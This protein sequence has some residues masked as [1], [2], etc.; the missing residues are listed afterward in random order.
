MSAPWI[1]R[2]VRNGTDEYRAYLKA[3]FPSGEGA[4]SPFNFDGH[5]WRYY[6]S[7]FDDIGGYDIIQR[8]NEDAVSA[9][10][11]PPAFPVQWEYAAN[12]TG[13]SLR[14]WFASNAPHGAFVKGTG[15]QDPKNM[16][17]AAY[18]WADAML[19]ARGAA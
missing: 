9:P 1:Q 16:A 17:V 8:P 7:S 3:R 10:H 6:A 15:V 13:M 19:A 18:V 11:N 2:K 12:E 5:N 4:P 14:D